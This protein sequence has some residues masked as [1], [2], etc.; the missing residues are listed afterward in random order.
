[1]H[2]PLLSSRSSAQLSS[3]QAK[4]GHGLQGLGNTKEPPEP[5]SPFPELHRKRETRLLA[6]ENL[7]I[8]KCPQAIPSAGLSLEPGLV[9]SCTPSLFLSLFLSFFLSSL[10]HILFFLSLSPFILIQACA[11][12]EAQGQ[13]FPR[14]SCEALMN[15]SALGRSALLCSFVPS[16]REHLRPL[17]PPSRAGWGCSSPGTD[18]VPPQPPCPARGERRAP[19]PAAPAPHSRGRATVGV[20]PCAHQPPVQLGLALAGARRGPRVLGVA[21][22]LGGA[23]SALHDGARGSERY[24]SAGGT[25]RAAGRTA[26]RLLPRGPAGAARAGSE[27]GREKGGIRD[28]RAEIWDNQCISK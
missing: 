11:Y 10:I 8:E 4:A 28:N 22:A 25:K 14:H 23:R 6:R 18:P 26:K 15:L 24:G 13:T 16:D 19:V 1:M 12:T 9:I 17:G 7:S 3:V 5:S 21:Q 20:P 2:S 27:A